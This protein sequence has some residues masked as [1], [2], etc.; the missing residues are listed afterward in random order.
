MK[1]WFES[2]EMRERLL[3]SLGAIIV[4]FALVYEF[5]WAPLDKHH[6]LL[7]TEHGAVL[8]LRADSVRSASPRP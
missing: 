3:V 2:L 1:D 6:T 7:K 8:L 5:G 4:A